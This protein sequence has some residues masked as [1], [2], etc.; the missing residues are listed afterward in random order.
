MLWL[1]LETET[2]A[3]LVYPLYATTPTAARMPMMA[4]TTRSS[5]RVK[6]R[7]FTIYSTVIVLVILS[8]VAHPNLTHVLIMIDD[9]FA[10]ILT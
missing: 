1:D 8:E 7:W 6:A 2:L 10:T 9:P 5:M 3:L 4:T